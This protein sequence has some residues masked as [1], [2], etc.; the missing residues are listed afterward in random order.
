[1]SFLRSPHAAIL[2]AFAAFG[3]NVGSHGGALALLLERSAVSPEWFGIYQVLNAVA[4]LVSVSIAGAMSR[5]MSHRQF[6]LWAI[7][8]V[9]ATICLS[10]VVR[11]EFQFGLSIV[12][13]GFFYSFFDLYMNAEATVVE[14]GAKR[15]LFG[16]FHGTAS[17]AMAAAGLISGMVSQWYDPAWMIILVLAT[18]ALAVFLVYRNLREAS[19]AHS[20]VNGANA[21]LKI[22]LPKLRLG[23]LGLVM[24]LNTGCEI[25]AIA[26]SGSLLAVMRPELAAYSGLGIAFFGLCTGV[27]RLAGDG[28]RARIGDYRLLRLSLTLAVIGFVV[29]AVSQNFA[30]STFAFALVGAGLGMVYP[31]LFSAAGRT[32]PPQARASAMSFAAAVMMPPRVVLPAVIGYLAG[33]FGIA[34]AFSICAV[35]AVLA[36]AVIIFGLKSELAKT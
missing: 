28:I 25:A 29:L 27:M 20:S 24:G 4:G 17:L 7:P 6:M 3:V 35:S 33:Q 31:C 8:I 22:K 32:V 34:G 11:S 1:M 10:L 18:S 26:W 21:A 14:H 23:L 36:L 19:S 15:P 12:A 9:A 5:L 16:Q 2:A 13:I 30:L